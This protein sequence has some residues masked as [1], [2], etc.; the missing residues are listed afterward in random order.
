[1]TAATIASV[2]AAGLLALTAAHQAALAGGARWSVAA[3]AGRAGRSG[4]SLPTGLR[5]ASAVAAI[6]LLG[7]AWTALAA[8]SV[9]ARGP[10]PAGALHAATWVL[11]AL[12]AG[13]TAANLTARH[14]FERWVLSVVTAALAVLLGVVALA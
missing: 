2:V 14:W 13:N 5:I 12:F 6:A 10:L 7:A 11:V 1:M 3:Y 8:G 4:A 9:L